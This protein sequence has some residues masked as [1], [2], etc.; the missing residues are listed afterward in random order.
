[1]PPA[2]SE[3]PTPAQP[4]GGKLGEESKRYQKSRLE[5]PDM[6]NSEKLIAC[7]PPKDPMQDFIDAIKQYQP[8]ADSILDKLRD[9]FA[10]PQRDPK[11]F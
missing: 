6:C 10:P 5:L 4:E 9:Y 7:E 1:M 2:K 8:K 3:P 11:A